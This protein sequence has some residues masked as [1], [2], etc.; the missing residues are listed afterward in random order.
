MDDRFIPYIDAVNRRL[1]QLVRSSGAPELLE[2]SMSYSLM[3]GGKR[4]RPLFNILAHL[5]IAGSYEKTL[6]IAC[7]IEMIHTYSLIHDDLPAMD[8]DSLRRGRPTNHKV[9]GEAQAILAGDGLLNLAFEV[10]LKNTMKYFED[11]RL[12]LAAIGYI[13]NAA[14]V[15]GMIAGQVMD[16]HLEG[17]AASPDDLQYIHEKKTAA[18]INSALMSGLITA[19]GSEKQMEAIGCFGKNIGLAFQIVDDI[20]DSTCTSE[21]LGKT[22]GKDEQDHKLTYVLIYGLNKSREMAAKKTKE[23]CDSLGIFGKKAEPLL[24]LAQQML[25]RGN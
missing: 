11:I 20:L 13:V 21:Q 22:P 17:A 19:G 3:A 2:Q 12:Q 10:M 8:D 4:L 23:A 6:D 7:A 25:N 5:L 9:F 15:S 14:G 18:L 24:Y 1:V 16:I